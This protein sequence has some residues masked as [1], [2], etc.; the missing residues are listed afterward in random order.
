MA[1]IEA[2]SESAPI[3][4]VVSGAQ[5][6]SGANALVGFTEVDTTGGTVNVTAQPGRFYTVKG[7][8]IASFAD[9]WSAGVA[10]AYAV[11]V[12][13][14]GSA[15]IDSVLYPQGRLIYRHQS[16]DGT[17][18]NFVVSGGREPTTIDFTS[19][20]LSIPTYVNTVIADVDT[21]GGTIT[22]LTPTKASASDGWR[23]TFIRKGTAGDVTIEDLDSGTTVAVLTVDTE[24]VTI[25]TDGTDWYFV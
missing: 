20:T 11:F 8:N 13:G 4:V 15:E 17:V 6:A 23:G 5:G 19:P 7:G 25:L 12:V 22:V 21:A 10:Q 24:S 9:S 16:S 2:V 14:S 18:T 3:R 1:D